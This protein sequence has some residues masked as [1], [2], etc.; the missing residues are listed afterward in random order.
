MKS[1]IYC[2]AVSN[3]DDE[4]WNFVWDRYNASNVGSE[5]RLFLSALSCSKEIWLLNKYLN[6]SLT[7]GSGI[8]KAD[9]KIV[10]SRIASNEIGR[11]LAFNF[12]RDKWAKV[13]E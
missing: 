7:E 11:D 3:G 4:E 10:I 8:R 12:I 5:K 9:G 1:T 2:Q 6:M 13:L